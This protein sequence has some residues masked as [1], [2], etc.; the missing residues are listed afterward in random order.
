M[1][2]KYG[3]KEVEDKRSLYNKEDIGHEFDR[4]A[5]E[6]TKGLLN[7]KSMILH[8]KDLQITEN[9]IPTPTLSDESPIT[10]EEAL[11]YI[12]KKMDSHIFIERNCSSL[13]NEDQIIRLSKIKEYIKENLK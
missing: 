13:M 10:R 4:V 11:E 7:K 9:W 6:A 5:D 12:T 2:G 8:G 1:C 3:N